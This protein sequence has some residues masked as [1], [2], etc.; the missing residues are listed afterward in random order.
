MIIVSTFALS[1]DL[2]LEFGVRSEK[3]KIVI[4]PFLVVRLNDRIGQ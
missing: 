2:A 3:N 1:V 4:C